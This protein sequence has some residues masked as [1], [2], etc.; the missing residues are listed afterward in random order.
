MNFSWTKEQLEIKENAI[1]F[2]QKQ[3]NDTVY[4]RDERSEFSRENWNKCAKHGIL[5]LSFPEAYGGTDLDIESV[6]LYME[7]LGYG[8]R[9]NALL[10]G[11]NAQMWS[12][13][14]PIAQIGTEAQKEQFLNPL[15]SG[16]IIGAH[17]MSEPMSGS[18]A[19]GMYTKATKVDGGYLLNGTKM[20]VTNA[21]VAD[22]AVVFATTDRKLGR[23][24]ISAFIV[25]TDRAGFSRGKDLAKMGMKTCTMGELFLQDCFVPDDHLLGNEGAGGAIFTSSMEWERSCI[26]GS[27]IGE[28]EHQLEKCVKYANERTQFNQSIDKFQSISNRISDMKIRLETARLLLYKVAWLKS[29]GKPTAID[30]ALAKLHIS[31]AYVAS[32][33]D[34]IRI[35]GGYGY[36]SEMGIE[37]D[38]R[39]AIGG[40]LYSGTSDI[41]RN[42]IAN[43]VKMQLL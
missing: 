12:V 42:I 3:L 27:H 10:F 31:E 39:D 23:W 11:L 29:Q 19:F 37:K 5:G 30:A 36:L 34:A 16:E 17:G 24:G 13:Q 18:D 25:E 32:S 28:M 2:A 43:Q 26:L 6:M 14:Y 21:P 1:E 35:F 9:D 41:Q 33:L 8:T 38:L 4:E 40:T 7:G 22:I 20:F 15:I